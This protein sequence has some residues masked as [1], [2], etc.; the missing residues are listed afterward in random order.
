[1]TLLQD[2]SD[3]PSK[4]TKKDVDKSIGANRRRD[5]YHYEEVA[6][7][8]YQ[9][10]GYEIVARN[11]QAGHREIDLIVRNTEALIFVEVKGGGAEFMG[12][13]SHRVDQRKQKLLIAAAQQYL[14]QNDVNG[15]DLCFDVLT[16]TRTRAGEQI[17]RYANAFSTD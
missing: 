11:Y 17:E 4:P 15:L 16:V 6:A 14:A 7:R 5:G 8:Y 10:L 3:N 13:P 1:M 2:N 12:H 9:D